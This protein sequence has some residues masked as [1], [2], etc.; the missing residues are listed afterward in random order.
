M[1][2]YRGARDEEDTDYEDDGSG[3]DEAAHE[4]H[5]YGDRFL[6]VGEGNVRIVEGEG[7]H[8]RWYTVQRNANSSNETAW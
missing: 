8:V 2:G 7:S 6:D 5:R 4:S 1:L 3:N